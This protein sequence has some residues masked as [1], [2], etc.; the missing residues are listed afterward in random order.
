MESQL[1]DKSA[2]PTCILNR[3]SKYVETVREHLVRIA[4]EFGV[5][6][7]IAVAS[8]EELT[9]LAARAVAEHSWPVVA[10]GGDGTINAVAGALVG[11]GT[12]LGI[13]PIG[14]LN[15][16]AKDMGIP[17]GLEAAVRNIFTG[18]VANVDVGEVNGRVFV[19]NSGIGLYP[20]I[21]RQREEKQREGHVKPVAFVLA[22]GS[23]LRRYSELRV[24]LRAGEAEAEVQAHRTPFV[25]VGNNRYEISGLEIGK[26]MSLVSGQLWACMA[27]PRTNRRNLVRMALRTLTGRV[28]DHELHALEAREI[29]VHTK[30][31]PINVSIDGEVIAMDAPLHYRICPRALGVIVP[32]RDAAGNG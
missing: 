3:A 5:Q 22:V 28:S 8:G 11:S 29:W 20:R 13:I 31:S 12:S 21:V 32:A 14:T 7:R 17:L 4:G 19:N 23:V 9:A 26:R 27:P 25:F 18:R 1:Q 30:T 6:A 2:G 24:K 10:G 16:F 15:H